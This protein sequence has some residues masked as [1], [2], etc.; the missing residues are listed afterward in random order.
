MTPDKLFSGSVTF[1]ADSSEV[2]Q[3]SNDPARLFPIITLET[4]S[5]QILGMDL[6]PLYRADRSRYFAFCENHNLLRQTM[7]KDPETWLSVEKV[8]TELNEFIDEVNR[9]V[10]QGLIA[11]MSGV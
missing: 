9:V 3:T 1:P 7:W 2:S 5:D 10:D 4:Y 11:R 6:S 8:A